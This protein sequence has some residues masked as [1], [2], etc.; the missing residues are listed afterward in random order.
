MVN[1]QQVDKRHDLFKISLAGR[2]S[3]PDCEQITHLRSKFYIFGTKTSICTNL[4]N[5][6]G[7][8]ALIMNLYMCKD[9]TSLYLSKND[10]LLTQNVG[11][12]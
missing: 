9:G 4:I 11:E 1:V 6:A 2:F 8:A 12:A 3:D 10:Q 7:L 5:M